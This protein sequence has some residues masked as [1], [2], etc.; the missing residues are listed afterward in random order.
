[1]IGHAIWKLSHELLNSCIFSSVFCIGFCRIVFSSLLTAEGCSQYTYTQFSHCQLLCSL[2]VTCQRISSDQDQIMK[3][4]FMMIFVLLS[5]HQILRYLQCCHV[6]RQG[7]LTTLSFSV[8]D[9]F[10]LCIFFPAFFKISTGI[11]IHFQWQYGYWVEHLLFIINFC[12]Q[13]KLLLSLLFFMI[14]LMI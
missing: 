5:V 11:S 4:R 9:V 6:F 10:N 13:T 14:S 1:M 8:W 2:S 7:C 3:R 12:I